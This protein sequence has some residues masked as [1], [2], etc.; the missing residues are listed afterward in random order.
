MRN[1]AQMKYYS[2]DLRPKIIN[3]YETE[4]IS[5]SKN[6]QA[7]L[8]CFKFRAKATQTVPVKPKIFHPK[9]TAALAVGETYP[10][11]LGNFSRTN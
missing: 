4:P 10:R 6:S 2:V 7:I 5:L 1:S 8:C 3:V 11:K 9:P